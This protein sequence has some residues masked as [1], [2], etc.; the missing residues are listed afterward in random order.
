MGEKVKGT[1]VRDARPLAERVYDLVCDD[2]VNGTLAPGAQLVQDQLAADYGVSR[3]PVRDVLTRLVHE[4]MADFI[5]GRGYFVKVLSYA[6]VIDVYEVRREVEALA[7]RRFEGR[8]SPM[9]LARLEMSLVE[10][11]AVTDADFDEIFRTSTDFHLALVAPCPNKYMLHSLQ[12]IWENPVQRRI[13]RS[14]KND[15]AKAAGVAAKHRRLLGL[16]R[17]GKTEELIKELASCHTPDT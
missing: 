17:A 12:G 9:E 5:P 14:Y 10:A 15:G 6:D 3:M 11:E 7:I 16:A 2:I 1:A 13:I 4:G 8:Y